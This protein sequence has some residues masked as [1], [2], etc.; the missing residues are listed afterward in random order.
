MYRED[1][2]SNVAGSIINL[3]ILI[4]FLKKYI[5]NKHTEKEIMDALPL[6]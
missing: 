4:A 2:L 1:E 6:Q 5:N 3:C